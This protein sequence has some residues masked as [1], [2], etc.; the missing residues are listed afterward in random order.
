MTPCSYL[1]TGQRRAQGPGPFAAHGDQL[2]DDAVDLI[3][4][5]LFPS[6]HHGSPTNKRNEEGGP[7]H[8]VVWL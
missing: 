1:I 6:S 8:Y 2:I 3:D 7:R 4:R 5:V